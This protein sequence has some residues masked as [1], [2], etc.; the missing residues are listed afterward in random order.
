MAVTFVKI[1]SGFVLAVALCTGMVLWLT[2]GQDPQLEILFSTLLMD[3]RDYQA[4]AVLSYAVNSYRH[5]GIDY[6][7]LSRIVK[8]HMTPECYDS[9]EER[10]TVYR[11]SG[12]SAFIDSELAMVGSAGRIPFRLHLRLRRVFGRWL[13]VAADYERLPD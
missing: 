8:D 5:N 13:V 10:S 7:G 12:D 3:A 9:I 1:G 11:S 2:A 6:G 4:D